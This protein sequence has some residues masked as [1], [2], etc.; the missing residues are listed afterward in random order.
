L[1]RKEYFSGEAH[2]CLESYFSSKSS[3]DKKID[4]IISINN[5]EE[6]DYV[7]LLKY[8]FCENVNKIYIQC[9]NLQ[10]LDDLYA[11]TPKELQ[12]LNLSKIPEL[13]GSAGPNNLFFDTMIPLMDLE[14]EDYLMIESDTQPITDFWIDDL[15]SYCDENTFMIAGSIYRGK[16][17]LPP[18]EPWTGH[19]NG[20]SVYRRSHYLKYFL[21][22]SKQTIIYRIATNKN[23]FI[24]FDVGMHNFSGTLI[25]KKYFCNPDFPECHLVNSKIISNYSLPID[26]DTTIDSV[27]KEHPQTIIL[28]KKWN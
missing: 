6:I 16:A 20:V 19:L 25:G 12:K 9:N 13:G 18:H 26:A 5:G 10:G 2:R 4:V 28:H 27:K 1:T 17:D 24:S 21:I 15:Q 22:L 23:H 3:I 11:R 14:Y 8:Q 7:D